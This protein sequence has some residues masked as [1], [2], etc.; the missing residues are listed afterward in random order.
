MEVENRNRYLTTTILATILIFSVMLQSNVIPIGTSENESQASITIIDSVDD[1]VYRETGEPAEE[2]FGFIDVEI[3]HLELK[4]EAQELGCT[5]TVREGPPVE[6]EYPDQ[7]IFYTLM[8]DENNDPTDNYL[9]YP[10][11]DID[12]MYTVVYTEAEGW[13]IVREVY[14]GYW[15]IEDTEADFGLASSYPG[16][17][18]IDMWIPLTEL[19]GFI[20]I[21][22]WKVNTETSTYPITF[23]AL[24]DFVPDEGLA[25]L[26]I[27]TVSPIL[28]RPD[29]EDNVYSN[30]EI[31]ATELINPESITKAIFEYSGDGIEWVFIDIDT[32]GT[33][34]AKATSNV[35]YVW[36]I[37]TAYW[38]I[39]TLSEGWYYLRVTMIDE[40]LNS[41]QDLVQVYVDPTPP[42]PIVVT[43]ELIDE[44]W[45]N[46]TG[47]VDFDFTTADENVV[48]IKVEY[49]QVPT[50]YN[51]SVPRKNQ[52]DY[53]PWKN[54]PKDSK[55]WKEDS[56]CGP[57]SAGSSLWYF[58]K[59]Y[60][61]IYGNLTKENGKE[62]NQTEL[63]DKL[64]DYT[65]P[66]NEKTGRGVS[67]A[68]MEK[69]IKDWIKDHGGC[70][71]VEY[72][73]KTTFTFKKY[74]TELL[75]C[76][77]VLVSTDSH[78]MVGNS[79]NLTKN[80]N[81]TYEVDFM[82][83]WTG[84]YITVNMSKDGSF[85]WDPVKQ[86]QTEGNPRPKD[87][88][89]VICPCPEKEVMDWKLIGTDT[90]KTD[91]LSVSWDTSELEPCTRYLIRVTMTDANNRTGVDKMLLH[92]T[93]AVLK[94]DINGDR[95]VNIMDI[96]AVAQAFGSEE[97]GPRWNP[98]ADLDGNGKVNILDLSTVAMDFGKTY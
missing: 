79:V 97:G 82:D 69:G 52:H 35:T 94:T 92:I 28:I 25:Y 48:S 13:T 20:E 7:V 75:E 37:W 15:M 68:Q 30:I 4:G 32:D 43:P 90:D 95:K 67:D 57:T 17:F 11:N 55:K 61:E 80:A 63:I 26:E 60:P 65:N 86:S 71:T 19:P 66:N 76:Q 58:A 9:N 14:D 42:I 29:D 46:V 33:A 64:H 39:D 88:M 40:A 96:A 84:K 70:L 83:P 93:E 5:I 89:F 45:A 21:M 81:G 2:D 73:N 78:W 10:F 72:V 98:E 85:K 31:A 18:S 22:P 54:Q 36:G 87:T 1:L 59:K 47:V 24:C 51:K 49:L 74:T 3:V 12:T 41:G 44:L 23:P 62:L 27:P 91:G 16:G 77:D 56:S 6:L 34:T 38:T 50:Y 53:G 8:L